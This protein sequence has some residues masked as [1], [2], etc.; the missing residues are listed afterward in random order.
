[1]DVNA[2]A[3]IPPTPDEPAMKTTVDYVSKR[4][5]TMTA[6]ERSVILAPFTALQSQKTTPP[7]WLRRL[8]IVSNNNCTTEHKRRRSDRG[9]LTPSVGGVYGCTFGNIVDFCKPNNAKRSVVAK[10]I[11]KFIEYILRLSRQLSGLD[12]P[13]LSMG[14]DGS[15]VSRTQRKVIKELARTKLD[16]KYGYTSTAVGATAAIITS[17]WMLLTPQNAEDIM[18]SDTLAHALASAESALHNWPV[19]ASDV[20]QTHESA[21]DAECR[22]LHRAIKSA[23]IGANLAS[24]HNKSPYEIVMSQLHFA[25]LGAFPPRKLQEDSQSDTLDMI[26]NLALFAHIN[27]ANNRKFISLMNVEDS[28]CA[29]SSLER[30]EQLSSSCSE[31]S[32]NSMSSSYSYSS[33]FSLCGSDE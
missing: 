23:E 29:I 11:S 27:M 9:E 28:N 1:M 12:A 22:A 10:R 26:D 4:D 17:I 8:F 6:L 13:Y 25:L 5:Q 3:V 2:L 24:D 21:L 15:R 18:K 16:S 30:R 33:S 7:L 32:W 14:L 19:A 20:P 31:S